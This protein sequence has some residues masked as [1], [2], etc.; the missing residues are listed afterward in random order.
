MGRH[1]LGKSPGDFG[2]LTSTEDDTL[3]WSK[4]W[5]L[6]SRGGGICLTFLAVF[7]DKSCGFSCSGGSMLIMI[8]TSEIG[9]LYKSTA[10]AEII[11]K[12]VDDYCI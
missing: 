7:M 1:S 2:T 11:L 3:S 6:R 4:V 5:A 10:L 8:L 9:G 12:K